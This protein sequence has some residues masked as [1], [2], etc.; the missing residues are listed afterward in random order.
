MSA[1]ERHGL[2]RQVDVRGRYWL[3]SGAELIRECESSPGIFR[4]FCSRYGSPLYSRR[5][6]RPDVFRIRLGCL[7]GVGSQA[8]WY[9]IRD[10]LPRFEGGPE[11]HAEEGAEKLGKR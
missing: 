8:P 7:D 1:V 9:E 5:E 3:L 11:D 4:A 10:E 6:S 2:Q